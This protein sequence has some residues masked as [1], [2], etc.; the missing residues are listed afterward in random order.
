M[1]SYFEIAD[2]IE[3]IR[4]Y[5][6]KYSNNNCYDQLKSEW[7]VNAKNG[8]ERYSKGGTTYWYGKY[9]VTWVERKENRISTGHFEEKSPEA[10]FCYSFSADGK[11]LHILFKTQGE[12]FV[13]Y[14]NEGLLLITYE[15]SEKHMPKLEAIGYVTEVN[16]EIFQCKAYSFSNKLLSDVTFR[17]CIYNAAKD[18]GYAYHMSSDDYNLHYGLLD[19]PDKICEYCGLAMYCRK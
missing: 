13:N 12:T 1:L 8:F 17:L 7:M 11:L 18:K 3:K 15:S 9:F 2:I 6:R 5:Y 4:Y 16:D 14:N 10:D 19:S